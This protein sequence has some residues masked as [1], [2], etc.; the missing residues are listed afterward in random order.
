MTVE[1]AVLVCVRG[2]MRRNGSGV[3]GFH[4]ALMW[5]TLSR[6]CRGAGLKLS[7]V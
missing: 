1:S 5:S 6:G 3:Q 7:P 2:F 4:Q